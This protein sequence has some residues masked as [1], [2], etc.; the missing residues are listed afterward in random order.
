MTDVR[1]CLTC[2]LFQ[3]FDDGIAGFA[4]IVL[5]VIRR[6]TQ[7]GIDYLRFIEQ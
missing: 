5:Y 1:T 6:H 7:Q 2:P 4:L 3:D